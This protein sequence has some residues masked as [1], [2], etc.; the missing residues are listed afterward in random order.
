MTEIPLHP[1]PLC[2]GSC[3]EDSA[4]TTGLRLT[5]GA[6]LTGQVEL[7]AF[8]YTEGDGAVD[9]SAVSAAAAR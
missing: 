2:L 3:H 4:T 8:E 7:L 9:P 5:A 1:H 6:A